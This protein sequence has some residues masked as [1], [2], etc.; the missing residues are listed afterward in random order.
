MHAPILSAVLLASLLAWDAHA[1]WDGIVSLDTATF[2][3]IVTGDR[4]VIAKFDRRNPHGDLMMQWRK[5][6]EEVGELGPARV[7]LLPVEVDCESEWWWNAQDYFNMDLARRFN[8]TISARDFAPAVFLF[9][10]GR[11]VEDPIRMHDSLSYANL[12]RF[13]QKHTTD[14]WY[15]LPGTLRFLDPLAAGFIAAGP[16]RWPDIVAEAERLT[17]RHAAAAD[18]RKDADVYIAAMRAVIRDGRNAVLQEKHRISNVLAAAAEPTGEQQPSVHRS[19]NER[20]PKLTETDRA[21]LERR[22]NILATFRSAVAVSAVDAEAAAAREAE[23][24]AEEQRRRD[25]VVPPRRSDPEPEPR[26][27]EPAAAA[28]PPVEAQPAAPADPLAALSARETASEP[29][30]PA[31]VQASVERAWS[32]HR[33]DTRYADPDDEL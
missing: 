20:R 5:F 8:V 31:A 27:E 29:A 1:F 23:R 19:R 16:S 18:E 33:A 6:A 25:R 28:P 9:L 15:A 11:S 3:K 2:D 13:V 4:H 22:L 14:V 10:R 24:A 17:Q 32:Q 21:R 26:A 30:D 12:K 7:D